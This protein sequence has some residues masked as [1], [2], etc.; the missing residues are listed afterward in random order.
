MHV[1]ARS[2]HALGGVR[3][4]RSLTLTADQI[5]THFGIP[6]TTPARTIIDLADVLPTQP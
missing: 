4:H 6:V 1:T 3:V 5:T 2:N